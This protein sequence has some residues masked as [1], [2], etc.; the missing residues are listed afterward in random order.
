MAL[1]LITKTR[2]LVKKL[3]HTDDVYWN[4]PRKQLNIYQA[5]SGTDWALVGQVSLVRIVGYPYQ[6]IALMDTLTEN[7]AVEL[8]MDSA[9]G[10]SVTAVN[11]GGMEAADTLNLFASVV[12]EYLVKDILNPITYTTSN[13][14]IGTT[15]I[16]I[17]PPKSNRKT[18]RITNQ[19]NS[20]VFLSLSENTNPVFGI[21]LQ[22][23]GDYYHHSEQESPYLGSIWGQSWAAN[24]NLLIMEGV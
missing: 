10:V 6:L 2:S 17:L 14:I 12:E 8:G 5:E 13:T 15:P 18:F 3:K 22:P 4:S 9:I 21:Q 16:K 7:I 20:M 11:N 1:N 24:S 19:S 23:N